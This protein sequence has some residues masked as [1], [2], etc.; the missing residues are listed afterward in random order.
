LSSLL[1][2]G[3]VLAFVAAAIVAV[4][5]W[6]HPEWFP[7]PK[8]DD[9]PVQIQM[10]IEK[11]PECV[12]CGNA[13]TMPWP[14]IIA[15]GKTDVHGSPVEYRIGNGESNRCCVAHR[16][17]LERRLE[18]EFSWG[19]TIIIEAH[20]KVEQHFAFLEMGG[21]LTWAQC[22]A[23]KGMERIDELRE[24]GLPPQQLQA[25]SLLVTVHPRKED[26]E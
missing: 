17:M 12:V 6:W 26:E 16:R 19:R 24:K 20:T 13:A 1:F 21:L 3:V 11:D 22:E 5:R 14:V 18:H 25:P 15:V 10:E 8:K 7:P 9:P 2:A 4:M 23:S